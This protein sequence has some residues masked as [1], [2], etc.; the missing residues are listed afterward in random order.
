LPFLLLALELPGVVVQ[1]PV[2]SVKFQGSDP[3]I[4]LSLHPFGGRTQVLTD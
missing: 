4:I 3:E 1:H 2:S